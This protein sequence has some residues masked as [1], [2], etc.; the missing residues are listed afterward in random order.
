MLTTAKITTGRFAVL[1]NGQPTKYFIVNGDL[2]VSGNS[3][4]MYGASWTDNGECRVRWIGSLA[5]AKKAVKY[6][7]TK[8]AA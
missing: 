8:A 1:W 4:N 7:L 5:A 2:G 6:W 3:R